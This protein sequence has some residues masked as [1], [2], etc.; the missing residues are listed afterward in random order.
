MLLNQKEMLS[1][2]EKQFHSENSP[3]RGYEGPLVYAVRE[4]HVG[5]AKQILEKSE[6]FLFYG[7]PLLV[8]LEKKQGKKQLDIF[9]LLL[10]ILQ[11]DIPRGDGET[12][13]HEAVRCRNPAIAGALVS[14]GADPTRPN[15]D[16]YSPRDLADK[17]HQEEKDEIRHCK[18]KIKGHEKNAEQ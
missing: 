9:N 15:R 13:L 11:P 3:L 18:K 16:G 12:V 10:D 2:T 17:L 14:R 7:D 5:V 6:S 8:A 1:M 4:G